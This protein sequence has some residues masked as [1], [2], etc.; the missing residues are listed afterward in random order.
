MSRFGHVLVRPRS[1]QNPFS[2][3]NSCQYYC[4]VCQDEVDSQLES[5]S[6]DGIKV[7]RRRCLRCGNHIEYGIDRRYLT[8]DSPLNRAAMKWLQ[9]T[10]KDRS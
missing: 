10:G 2:S 7:Y 5:G 4:S 3:S 1:E 8:G 6:A 9:E